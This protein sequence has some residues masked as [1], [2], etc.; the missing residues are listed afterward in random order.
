MLS[1]LLFIATCVVGTFLIAGSGVTAA[2]GISV[3]MERIARK[4]TLG[5]GALL[6]ENAGLLSAMFG[7]VWRNTD[8]FYAFEA[9]TIGVLLLSASTLVRPDEDAEELDSWLRWVRIG[10]Y[11][12]ALASMAT[13]ALFRFTAAAIG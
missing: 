11:V 6:C 8:P 2:V 12:G 4:R 7:F 13:F 1:L 5:A 3:V 9:I 10:Q